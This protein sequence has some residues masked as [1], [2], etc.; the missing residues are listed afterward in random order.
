M[1]QQIIP[2]AQLVPKFQS[3]RRC[4]NY[5]VLQ[6]IPCSSECKII[7]QIL[8][9]HPLSYA[10]TATADV[11]VVYL[12]QFWKT[13][14][15]VLN[16]KDKI[17]FK[18]DTQDIT[19]IVDMF[20]DTLHLP[21]ETPD[22]PFIA[23]FNIKDDISLVS[24]YSTGNGLFR[25][26]LILNALLTDEIYAT[27]DYKEYETVVEGGQDDESYT[28]KFAAS[29]LHDDVDDFGNR[30]EP[31]SHKEHPK[32]IDDDD[33]NKEE[34]KDDEMA[35]L[36]NRTTKMQ[37][38]IPTTPRSPRINLSLDKNI[39]L[40]LTDTISP[41]TTTTPKDPQ[42]ER[43]HGKV[44]TADQFWKVHGRVD[45]VLHEISEVH[46]LISKDF[47]A[48]APKIIEDLFKHYVQTNVI[49]VHPT[50]TTSTDKTSSAE[51]Q[52]QL[53]LKMKSNF[54]DQANDP[55]L[56]DVLKRK[57]ENS[58]TSNTSC[59]D[60]DFHSQHHGDHQDK[61][62]PP[63][64]EK[65]VKRHKTSKRSKSAKGSSSKQSAKKSTAYVSKQ[66]QQQ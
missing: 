37:T 4:N 12:Q 42:K 43:L 36:E 30:I 34:K 47:D 11:L 55:T 24:V 52:Q 26:M 23:P 61:D 49:Q 65:R 33:E 51:L 53:Y 54:Q 63:E 44:G 57:F 19:Y 38:P 66:Q 1:A 3:I 62:A 40:E 20:C 27:D 2:V 21:V 39:T 32:V 29:M 15:K 46:I 10:L 18:L 5:D 16:T 48:H 41:S 35:S 13:V 14:S 31:E 17:K 58:F 60:D 6:S 50:T 7:G 22:N 45:Q 28:S 25:W 64:G 9:D 56:W 59:R 8:L